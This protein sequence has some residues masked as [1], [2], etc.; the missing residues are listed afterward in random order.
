MQKVSL[1]GLL[2]IL[3]AE[4]PSPK[5]RISIWSFKNSYFLGSL[6]VL[7]FTSFENNKM[8]FQILNGQDNELLFFY[9]DLKTNELAFRGGDSQCNRSQVPDLFKIDLINYHNLWDYLFFSQDKGH[10]R[11]D[12]PIGINMF[13]KLISELHYLSKNHHSGKSDL[14]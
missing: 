2:L 11:L 4:D 8:A 12:W 6:S 7:T 9:A 13:K 10:W 5:D 14:F 1:V 3:V